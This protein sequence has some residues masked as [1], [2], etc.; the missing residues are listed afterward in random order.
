MINIDKGTNGSYC[1]EMLERV[2]YALEVGW[3]SS[4]ERLGGLVALSLS[5]ES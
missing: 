2:G 1:L 4:E 5:E 3:P